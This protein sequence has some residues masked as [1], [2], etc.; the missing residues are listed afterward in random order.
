MID[1]GRQKTTFYKR[2][3]VDETNRPTL[4]NVKKIENNNAADKDEGSSPI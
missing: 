4:S 2:M 3:T 1:Y